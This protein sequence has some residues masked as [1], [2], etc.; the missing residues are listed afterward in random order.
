MSLPLFIPTEL[1][2][3]SP[4]DILLICLLNGDTG[5]STSTTIAYKDDLY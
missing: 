3:G 5:Q 4:T 1:P 2:A